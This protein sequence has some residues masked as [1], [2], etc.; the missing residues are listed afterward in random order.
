[1]SANPILVTRTRGERFENH[2]RGAICI[3][4][5]KSEVVFEFG[6]IHGL[7]YSR[8]TLKLIQALPLVESGAMEVFKLNG[9]ELAICC[10]SHNGE[11]DH[12]LAVRSILSKIGLEEKHLL[13][14]P[15]LPTGRTAKRELLKSQGKPLPIH[16]NC[17]GK[18]AGFLALCVYMGWELDTYLDVD[19][20][21]QRLVSKATA[22]FFEIP[23]EQLILGEDGCSAPNY[24]C[25]LR[26]LA[27]GYKNIGFGND[28]MSLE[29]EKALN[30]VQNA[31]LQYPYMLGGELRFCSEIN[32]A[33]NAA[34]LGKTGADGVYC[35]I[36]P[37]MGLSI[38][39]KIDDGKMGPQ[40][41]VTQL[42]LKSLGIS[43]QKPLSKY[44]QSPV[45]NNNKHQV[46]EEACSVELIE[47]IKKCPLFGEGI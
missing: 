8:S 34:V 47:A 12:L 28:K 22:E 38:A 23:E 15:Q 4:N 18:H 10:G 40:Y 39:I 19:H 3:L 29:R 24:A 20:P 44:D 45:L 13:C 11:K 41:L 16:H 5:S 46:G 25:S 43:F 1:M 26:E 6:N 35:A 36:L 27:L 21:L 17:S 42:L 33:T 32:T 2:H 7:C 9:Q 37:E 14:G 30:R 31:C